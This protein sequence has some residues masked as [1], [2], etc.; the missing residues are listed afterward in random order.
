MLKRILTFAGRVLFSIW[1][2]NSIIFTCPS[3]IFNYLTQASGSVFGDVIVFKGK[4][5][6]HRT[7]RLFQEPG[8]ARTGS[9]KRDAQSLGCVGGRDDRPRAPAWKPLCEE[10][11]V[12]QKL[13]LRFPCGLLAST[14]R[15]V[16]R[17]SWG[18]GS[19]WGPASPWA[20][21]LYGEPL[22]DI[23]KDYF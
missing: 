23:W 8:C 20:G 3:W 18:P 4:K 7:D 15:N 22:F 9:V 5:R 1:E 10:T 11:M 16:F 17:A 13:G 2:T 14:R 21:R 19:P 6:K 12:V